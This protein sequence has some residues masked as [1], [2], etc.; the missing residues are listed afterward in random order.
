VNADPSLRVAN[1]TLKHELEQTMT[2]TLNLLFVASGGPQKP[3]RPIAQIFVKAFNTSV[4]EEL[5]ETA[6]ITQECFSFAEIDD[7]IDRLKKE[8]DA[9][10]RTA[11]VQ[12]HR[13]G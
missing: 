4:D 6:F 11:R 3:L 8:L 10:R 5:G 9:I 2:G 1:E 13:S 7:E 12:F